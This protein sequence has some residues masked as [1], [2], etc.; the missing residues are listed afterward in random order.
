MYKDR[1]IYYLVLLHIDK[2]STYWNFERGT[3]LPMV[4]GVSR[5]PFDHR[6]APSC[7]SSYYEYRCTIPGMYLG[8]IALL[9]SEIPFKHG[10]IVQVGTTERY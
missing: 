6:R 8:L 1:H 4:R 10:S 5:V 7:A 2:N 3:L 9:K